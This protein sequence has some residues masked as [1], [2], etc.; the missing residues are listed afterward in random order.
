MLKTLKTRTLSVLKKTERYT[1]TDMEYLLSGGFWITLGQGLS[2]IS[3]LILSYAFANLVPPEVFGNYR[4]ILSIAGILGAFTLP[5]VA[6]ALV[7]AVALHEKGVLRHTLFVRIYWGTIASGIALII[8]GY[9][10]FIEYNPSLAIALV[11]SAV[12]LPLY[13]PVQMYSSYLS[14][15]KDFRRTSLY[16]VI[17]HL[18]GS[19]ALLGVVF[20][21]SNLLV[22]VSAYFASYTIAHA[23]MLFYVVKRYPEVS[24]ANTDQS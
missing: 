23:L 7:R 8:A 14:G 18:A 5:G 4:F 19:L 12:F 24:D 11:I 3:G 16:V 20:F 13:D 17:A 21:T 22:L 10:L 9:Y 2:A 6:T 15:K 1:K